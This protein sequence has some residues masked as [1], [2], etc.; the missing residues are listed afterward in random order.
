VWSEPAGGTSISWQ[1]GIVLNHLGERVFSKL[2]RFLVI[3]EGERYC[4]AL[5]INTYGGHGVSKRG[6]TKSEHAIIYTGRTEPRV[7]TDEMP[8]PQEAGMLSTPIRV[9][10]DNMTEQMDPMSRLDFGG[11]TKIHHNLKVKSFGLVNSASMDSLQRQFREVWD[12]PTNTPI[13]KNGDPRNDEQG[14]D[15]SK[16]DETEE[17][18]DDEDDDDDDSDDDDESEGEGE[19]TEEEGKR[20]GGPEKERKGGG[21]RE[22]EEQ[23][24]DW[25]ISIRHEESEPNGRVARTK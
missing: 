17:E 7:R 16:I 3:R 5:P 12:M 20:G 19:E 10:P 25:T 8:G 15:C 24:S 23:I 13:E 11:V 18:D 9:D 2:R 4:N 22:E 14:K 6:V 21:R 1:P